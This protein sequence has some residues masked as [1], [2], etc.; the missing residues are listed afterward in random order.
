[1]KLA[2][3]TFL[4]FIVSVTACWCQPAL[5]AD[6][7]TILIGTQ[8]HDGKI[9]P[10]S[11]SIADLADSYLWGWQVDIA[12][13]RYTQASWNVCNCYSQNGI[14][15]SYF[16]FNNPK[17]LGRSVSLALF[18]EP[19]LTY[20]RFYL[21]LRAAA[22]VSY[23]TRIYHPDKNPRNL[24]FSSPWSGLLM[25]QLNTRY[26]LNPFWIL[27]FGTSYHHIS[28]GGE[29]QPNLGMNFP[30]LS[31]GVEHATRYHVGHRRSR[32][33]VQDKSLR[34]YTGL[35]YNTRSVSESN[36]SSNERKIVFGL[37]GGFYKPIS[38]M[39]AFGLALELSHD[40]SLK[41]LAL[42][43]NESYDHRVV[44]GLARHHFLFG[45]FDFSQAIGFYLHKEYPSAH[46]VFQRYFIQ[47][48]IFEK[49][50][51][52]FSLKAHLHVA[53]QMDLRLGLLF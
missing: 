6:S 22:G 5:V 19:Q 8:A 46:N 38:H 27:R 11:K 10:H 14:S 53:E 3:A 52:G 18:A 4:G 2:C 45:R 50:Q 33:L 49:L 35:S 47:Y 32:Y 9:L 20:G 48:R 51:V 41:E 13:V 43:N 1:M 40:G 24:F 15:L 34:Y 25:A 30:A 44:S 17:E 23:L 16:D 21:S 42:Q 29:R 36:V 7:T 26:R 39:H 31:L 28:N 12:R 37:H